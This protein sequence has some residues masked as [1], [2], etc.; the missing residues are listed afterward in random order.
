VAGAVGARGG[1]HRGPRGPPVV[2]V[3]AGCPGPGARQ[4]PHDAGGAAR[5]EPTYWD[6]VSI[7]EVLAEVASALPSPCVAAPTAAGPSDPP[8]AGPP[9]ALTVPTAPRASPALPFTPPPPSL[10]PPPS[11]S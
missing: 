10:R 11:P 3:P 2:L 9:A 6:Q 5:P 7:D 1:L 8:A 4:V